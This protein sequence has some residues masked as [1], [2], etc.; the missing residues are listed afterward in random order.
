[1]RQ[2]VAGL[3]CVAAVFAAAVTEIG[4]PVVF[5]FSTTAGVR[6]GAVDYAPSPFRSAAAPSDSPGPAPRA[7]STGKTETRIIRI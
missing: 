7:T 4:A 6:P 5:E 2:V 1:M 3:A